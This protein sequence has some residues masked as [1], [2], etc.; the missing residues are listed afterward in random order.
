MLNKCK[1]VKV[2]SVTLEGIENILRFG[3]AYYA[4]TGDNLF[5][6]EFDKI[7]G[8]DLIEGL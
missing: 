7:G 3:K 5:A 1:D 6:N 8:I 4:Q 2:L